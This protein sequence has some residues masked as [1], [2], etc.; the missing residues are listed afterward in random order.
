MGR[1]ANIQP[2]M[3]ERIKLIAR[4][5]AEA[6]PMMKKP[7]WRK[8]Q[9]KLEEHL[10]DTDHWENKSKKLIDYYPVPGRTA[11]SSRISDDQ[12][13]TWSEDDND[14]S[15]GRHTPSGLAD[16][17]VGVCM[18][19][20][21]WTLRQA[22]LYPF[23]IRTAKYVSKLRWVHNAGGSAT[24]QIQSGKIENLYILATQYAAHER[25]AEA[26][27]DRRGMRS[28]ILDAA[29]MLSADEK[30]VSERLG[31]MAEWGASDDHVALGLEFEEMAPEVFRH[32]QVQG[33]VTR[34]VINIDEPTR[35]MNV[36]LERYAENPARR[37]EIEGMWSM[38]LRMLTRRPRWEDLSQEIEY[39]VNVRLLLDLCNAD[40]RG[41]AG[42]WNPDFENL[43]DEAE[44]SLF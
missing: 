39:D 38:A 40:A 32:M 1:E 24:G 22:T 17:S 21:Q 44:A 7:T 31:L 26:V 23:S 34:G 10:K 25:H 15:L 5:M 30:A 14:W 12:I 16:D 11:I 4:T 41:E 18:E 8:V 6:D 42:S 37:V 3:E 28:R 19:I 27:K 20:W 36:L 43:I 9:A 35:K 29:L 2:W 13:Y 33:Q